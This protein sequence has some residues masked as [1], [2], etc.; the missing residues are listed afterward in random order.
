ML[1][2]LPTL[3]QDALTDPPDPTLVAFADKDGDAARAADTPNTIKAASS[4]KLVQ[5]RFTASSGHGRLVS[6]DRG[7]SVS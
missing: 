7:E 5:T 6:P 1:E 3:L 4:P 2:G